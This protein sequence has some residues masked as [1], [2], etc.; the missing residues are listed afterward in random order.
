MYNLMFIMEKYRVLN[1]SDYGLGKR[2]NIVQISDGHL[3]IM[4][5]RRSRIIMKDSQK[6]MDIANALC[7]KEPQSSISLIISGPICSKTIKFLKSNLIDIVIDN[8]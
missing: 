6:I 1:P 5:K 8:Q 3:G 4:K 7:K 2:I